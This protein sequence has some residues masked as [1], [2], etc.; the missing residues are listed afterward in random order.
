[1]AVC[2]KLKMRDERDLNCSV[3][4]N[5]FFI[6]SKSI[7]RKLSGI[8]IY[9]YPPAFITHNTRN[10]FPTFVPHDNPEPLKFVLKAILI[11]ASYSYTNVEKYLTVIRNPYKIF[12]SKAAYKYKEA[13]LQVSITSA[14]NL[15]VPD[16][17]V[18]KLLIFSAFPLP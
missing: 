2:F 6:D 8:D 14:Y 12:K 3:F 7:L 11:D 10:Q 18:L 15:I 13:V 16:R 17:S 9:I 1:M 5:I 4:V